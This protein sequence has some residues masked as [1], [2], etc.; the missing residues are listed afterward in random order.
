MSEYILDDR[1]NE[2]RS[3]AEGKGFLSSFC[4]QSSYEAHPSLL[5][6]GPEA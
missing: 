4:G 3:P 2:V 5:Y 6:R 1:A